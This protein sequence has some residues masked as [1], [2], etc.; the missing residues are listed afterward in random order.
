VNPLCGFR[1]CLIL[2]AYS[3]VA[4]AQVSPP[5]TDE[6][7]D[8]RAP[9]QEAK[10]AYQEG[11]TH[12]NLGEYSE[13]VTAFRRAYELSSA[14]ALLFDIAQA[15]R[16]SGDCAKA[17][18]VYRHF[19]RLDPGSSRRADADSQS[20]ALDRQCGSQSRVPS[21]QIR[22]PDV[23]EPASTGSSAS[24][25]AKARPGAR[26]GWILLGAGV[27]VGLAAGAIAWW[28]DDRYSTWAHENQALM[29]PAPTDTMQRA[30]W[31]ARQNSNDNLWSS[32][33]NVDRGVL[34][35]AALST[36]CIVSA[37]IVGLVRLGYRGDVK[38]RGAGDLT[39]WSF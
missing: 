23:A 7:P 21:V 14:P 13:A 34:V 11:Q 33:R 16:L 32:I 26:L 8:L 35:A 2:L 3:G 36:A 9:E 5:S 18:E 12:Y 17:L 25:Q 30:A 39:S 6:R 29:M 19:V 31:I 38:P 27:G 1:V 4:S 10:R 37:T 15:Y 22:P 24:T 28:N 20:A